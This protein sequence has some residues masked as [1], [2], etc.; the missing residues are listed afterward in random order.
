MRLL[1]FTLIHFLIIGCSAP[2]LIQEPK[3]YS[4]QQVH[5]KVKYEVLGYGQGNT[6]EIANAN[7]KE[8]IAL[9]LSSKVTS[10]FTRSITSHNNAYDK[11]N[12]SYLKITSELKLHKLKTIKQEQKNN[13]FYVLL[14]YKN[15]DLAYKIKTTIGDYTCN[16]KITSHYLQNTPLIKK[17]TASLGCQLNFKLDRR[18]KAWY[19]SYKEYLFLLNDREFEE[20]YIA[21]ANDILEFK[22]SKMVLR[23]GDRF[24]FTLS[25]KEEGYV[26]LLNVYENGMV[27]LLQASIPIKQPIQVPAKNST[28]YFEAGLIKENENTYDLY[29]AIFTKQALDMS[30]FEYAHEELSQ[31]ELAHKFNE[32][33]NIIS[34]YEYSSILL[35]TKVK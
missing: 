3:W 30:R 14:K 6:L 17:L 13:I 19:L 16:E 33:I 20:L 26:T 11:H 23:D 27:T 9:S 35:R 31:S 8:K 5:S 18:N 15:L 2:S 4:H 22:A 24:Y 12:K 34:K 32:L 29:L 10:S 28:N 7:A 21:V 25:S 1:T